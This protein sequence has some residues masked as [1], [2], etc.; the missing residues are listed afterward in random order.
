MTIGSIVE[1]TYPPG[2]KDLWMITGE[3][4]VPGE[5]VYNCTEFIIKNLY[6]GRLAIKESDCMRT[7][8]EEPTRIFELLYL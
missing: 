7:I 4:K 3:H 5:R 6:D 8:M 1:V 2:D